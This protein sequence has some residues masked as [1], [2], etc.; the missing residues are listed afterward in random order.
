MAI[1]S[2]PI[3]DYALLGD[4]ETAVRL[5][6][7]GSTDRLCW[8]RSDDDACCAALLG[9]AENRRWR[10]PRPSYRTLTII[11]NALG[12]ADHIKVRLA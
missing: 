10:L 2:S 6:R 8:P 3:E 12:V 1:M 5:R 7:D 11:A 4:G 9:K